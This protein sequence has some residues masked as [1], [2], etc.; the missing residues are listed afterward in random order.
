MCKKFE[1]IVEKMSDE[2]ADALWDM[3]IDFVEDRN[4]SMGGISQP[5]DVDTENKERDDG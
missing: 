3:I 1:F 5:C 4:L 2:A